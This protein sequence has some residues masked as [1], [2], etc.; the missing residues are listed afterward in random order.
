MATPHEWEDCFAVL[1][2]DGPRRHWWQRARGYRK[3]L[4]AAACVIPLML[5]QAPRGAELYAIASDE[6]QAGIMVRTMASL[7]EASGLVGLFKVD[8]TRITCLRSG[9]TCEAMASDSASAWGRRPW[10][11]VCDELAMWKRT[12]GAV[13]FF[14]AMTTALPKVP[15][16]RLL[17]TTTPGDPAHWAR[18]EFEHAQGS[19]LWRVSAISG[20]PPWTDAAVLEHE[21]G[22]LPEAMYRQLFEAEWTASDDALVTL[23]DLKAA[24]VLDGPQEPRSGARYAIGVDI[25]LRNDATAVAVLHAEKGQ[26]YWV[27]SE[28]RQHAPTYV[29]DR[30][31]V[32][33]GSR[34]SEVDLETVG[35]HVLHL[36]REFNNAPVVLDPYQAVDLEQRLRRQ[37]VRVIRYTFTPTSIGRFAVELHLALREH[38]LLLP[39]DPDL[40]KEF[41]E[42]RFVETKTP[43][44][45]RVDHHRGKHDDRVIATGLAMTHLVGS[46]ERPGVHTGQYSVSTG[47]NRGAVS[48]RWDEPFDPDLY[49]SEEQRRLARSRHERLHRHRTGMER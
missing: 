2:L 9:A 39:D 14:N 10:L 38:R 33:K 15:G 20:P 5:E 48:I 23:D 7:I 45:F 40:L 43:G 18:D 21:R 16:S 19:P 25:G 35:R 30:M 22:R 28:K 3:T 42:A 37:G 4:G 49:P 44:V 26:A 41:A 13:A 17:V 24:A 34:R 6:D 1:D 47:G 8:A 31:S 27:A 46:I 32:F 36:S 11:I 29:L 12:S